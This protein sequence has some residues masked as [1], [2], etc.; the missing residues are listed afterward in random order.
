MTANALTRRDKVSAPTPGADRSGPR[1][2]QNRALGHVLARRGRRRPG[3][4]A[5]PRHDRR[6]ALVAAAICPPTGTGSS[7]SNGENIGTTSVASGCIIRNSANSVSGRLNDEVVRVHAGP[8]R[9]DL[10]SAG[11]GERG[12]A[13]QFGQAAAPSRVGL[14]DVAAV[15][16]QQLEAVPGRF[17]FRRWPAARSA[18]GGG[19]ARPDPSSRPGAAAPRSISG[20][21]RR[22]RGQAGSRSR[23]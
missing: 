19:V 5:R 10:L 21:T 23:R 16:D 9:D 13:Q 20:R 17:V 11:F 4:G 1:R 2:G 3:L 7:S 18:G 22:L 15:F 12:N 8:V 14:H 6:H